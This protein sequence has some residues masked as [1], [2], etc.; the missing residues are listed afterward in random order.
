MQHNKNT[1]F[2]M[3]VDDFLTQETLES[4]QE[5]FQKINYS[6][7]KNPEGQITKNLC[8]IQMMTKEMLLTF[9]YLLRENLF[10]TTAQALCIIIN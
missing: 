7:V 5:T 10:L 4:L 9:F 1:K 6:G 3:Y 2:V 8:F